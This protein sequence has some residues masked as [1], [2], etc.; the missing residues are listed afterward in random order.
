MCVRWK[1]NLNTKQNI[2]RILFNGN[3]GDSKGEGT[4][5]WPREEEETCEDIKNFIGFRVRNILP[6]IRYTCC[7]WSI[8]SSLRVWLSSSWNVG[9]FL[10]EVWVSVPTV[11]LGGSVQ[12]SIKN[13]LKR[14]EGQIT[15]PSSSTSR[16]NFLK[17]IQLQLHKPQC[18]GAKNFRS[19]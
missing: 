17:K 7:V 6:L 8:Y 4:G 5:K 14:E 18:R 11:S 12:A 10:V 1:N 16:E 9:L 3:A 15:Y 2:I 13:T 19:W